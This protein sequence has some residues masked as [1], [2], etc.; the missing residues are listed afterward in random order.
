MN[1]LSGMRLQKIAVFRALQLGDM[2]CSIPAIRALK[3][4]FPDASIT[5]LGLPWAEGFVKKF[6]RYF[7]DFILFPGFPGLPEQGF[8]TEEIIKFIRQ[9]NDQKFDLII[10]MQGNGSIVNSLMALLGGSRIAGYYKLGAY[11]PDQDLFMPYPEKNSEI[12]RHITLMEFLGVPSQG[13]QLEFPITNNDRANFSRLSSLYGLYPGKYVCMHTGARDMQ[14]WWP[15]GRFAKVADILAGKGYTVVFTGIEKEFENVRRV[16]S[17]MKFNAVNCAG[18]TDIGVLAEL[19]RNAKM[20][21]SNDTGLSHIAAAVKTPSVII[22]L[23]SD[24]ERWG[25][26]DKTLHYQVHAE[27][28]GSLDYILMN[29]ERALLFYKDDFLKTKV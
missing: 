25:P 7:S 12:L 20:L 5:L 21:F 1:K 18:K 13:H 19:I 8:G 11:C 10:Q 2:L 28:S 4:S 17:L 23:A 3:H 9:V 24:P 29:I 15:A 16:Q 6:S 22:F 27:N 14:R 26:L